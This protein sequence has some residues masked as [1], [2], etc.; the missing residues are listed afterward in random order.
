MV[1]GFFGL[2][3]RTELEIALEQN[4]DSYCMQLVVVDLQCD[5]GVFSAAMPSMAAHLFQGSQVALVMS[6][7]Q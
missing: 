7:L 4:N 3:D 6:M 5:L 1:E 2:R